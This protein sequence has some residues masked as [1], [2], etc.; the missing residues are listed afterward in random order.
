MK[1]TA[2]LLVCLLLAV[3]VTPCRVAA[4]SD[5]VI[6]SPGGVATI[7][8]ARGAGE[9]DGA[10]VLAVFDGM[11]GSLLYFMNDSENLYLG[12]WVPDTSLTSFDF[13]DAR[14]DS[15]HNGALDNGDDQL[16]LFGSSIFQDNHYQFFWNQV[17]GSKDGSGMAAADS[18]GAFF[19]ISHPLNSGDPKDISAAPGDTIGVCVQ[20]ALEALASFGRNFPFACIS[21][22][23][24]QAEYLDLVIGGGVTGVDS[25]GG[26][27][28]SS[29][30]TVR[31]N[32]LSSTQVARIEYT[33]PK[34][35]TR[36]NVALYN[37][38]GRKVLSLANGF[39]QAGKTVVRWQGRDERDI[40]LVPGMYFVRATIGAWTGNTSLLVIR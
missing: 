38:T 19:E 40:P 16:R 36:V 10:A 6:E 18:A 32:P 33:V 27:V 22:A 20:Y 2:W 30:L 4:H 7:D 15:D 13:F 21:H 1:K 25:D 37:L 29:R 11:P 35:G 26:F 3:C 23:N 31:P 17:D 12:L 5:D 14:F 39:Q 8:G 24:Q 34:G 28:P 9:W